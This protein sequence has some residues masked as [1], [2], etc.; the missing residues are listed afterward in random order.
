M[1]VISKVTYSLYN[2]EEINATDIFINHV[3]NDDD[4]GTVKDGRL[5]AMDGA[6]CKTCGK[7]ELQCF[8]HWGKVRL[9][10]THIIKP[11]YI[12]EVIRILNHICIRCGF[13]RSREPYIEDVTKMSSYAL[14]KLKDKILSK[15]KS[16]WNSKC[17]QQYQK[18]TFSKKKYVS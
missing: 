8:G 15:K 18:I 10:E 5:G 11:E 9:Y 1:A 6:L 7:T 13:L 2:Q 3:K 16:C 4:V 12:G 14:R 17:M